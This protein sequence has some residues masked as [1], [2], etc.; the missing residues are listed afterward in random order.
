MGAQ[1]IIARQALGAAAAILLAGCS[2]L[3]PSQATPGGPI[4][5]PVLPDSVE[6]TVDGT[7]TFQ[8]IDGFG[9]NVNGTY[10]NDGALA[11]A[12]DALHA[13]LGSTIF[14]VIVETP[15]WERTNDNDD[16]RRPDRE[17][18]RTIYARPE[19]Q[20]LFAILRHLGQYDDARVILNVMGPAPAWMGQGT[21][22]PWAEEEWAEMI[23]SLLVYARDE[24]GL[25]IDLLAPAN[26]M[27]LGDPEGPKLD[28]R[29]YVRM[30]R[31]LSERL[32]AE[33]LGDVRL[34]GPDLAFSYSAPSFLPPILADDLVMAKMA[35]LSV[36]DYSGEIDD[37]ERLLGSE[38][39]ATHGFW[40]TEYSQ[41]CNDCSQSAATAD[42]WVFGADTATFL[43]R[44]LEGGARA[45]LL[46]DGL[47]G[48]YVH[49]GTFDYWGVLAYDPA[50]GAFA[51]RPRFYTGAQ[52]FRFVRPGMVRVAADTPSALQVL[53]FVDPSSGDLSIVGRN[54][55]AHPITI[56]G[57]L[58]GVEAGQPLRLTQT[59]A[60]ASLADGGEVALEQGGAFS[61]VVAPDSIFAISTLRP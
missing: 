60:A 5:T 27:D 33:G 52:I 30:L 32:D 1:H 59:T 14:R 38:R 55:T 47:D 48:Y 35:T 50:T 9:V 56:A 57:T 44:Y 58:A 43:L 61:A 23:A 36:H 15:Y 7:R 6:L 42:S 28:P 18:Y 21:V 54:P 25:T 11:P 20:S 8:P 51:P 13:E 10:W 45:A 22:E 24:E 41:W 53:A 29:Q 31:T 49:H 12:L 34:V 3:R 17:A 40:V 16:P 4:P 2:F 46:Y 39:A 37:M 19:F 26:E